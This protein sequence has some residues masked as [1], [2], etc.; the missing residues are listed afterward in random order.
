VEIRK[1]HIFIGNWYMHDILKSLTHANNTFF[2]IQKIGAR[3]FM[4]FFVFISLK[5]DIF[6][7]NDK[8]HL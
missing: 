1:T 8:H 3:K 4:E 6:R 5:E 7:L 2:Q